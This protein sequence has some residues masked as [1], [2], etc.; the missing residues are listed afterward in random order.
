MDRKSFV[1]SEALGCIVIYSA[2]V[3]LHFVY[4]LSGGSA[5][6]LLFG[7]VNESVWE[8]VKVFSAAYAGWA[9]LQLMWIR[10]PFRRYTVSKCIGLYALMG[11]MIVFFY[12]CTAVAGRS[13]HAVNIISSAVI[14]ITA[15][16]ISCVGT[17]CDN[18][19]ADYFHPALM[20]ILLY[21]L[22]FFSFTIFPPK[23]GLFR[24]PEGGYG[25]SAI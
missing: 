23:L 21:Y 5:L 13:I 9:L 8:H 2:A 7:A 16:A 11:G 18:K 15:Q 4:E 6:G 10:A 17:I 25:I 22:M 3:F 24:A 1:I 12:I 14:L 20:L 19:L